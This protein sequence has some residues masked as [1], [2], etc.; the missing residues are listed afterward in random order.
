MKRER[1]EIGKRGRVGYLEKIR[2]EGE[3][4]SE[5]GLSSIVRSVIWSHREGESA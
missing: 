5:E 1:L 4:R 2:N 3:R